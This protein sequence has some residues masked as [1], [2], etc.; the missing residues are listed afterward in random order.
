MKIFDKRPLALILCIFTGGFSLFA[1][2]DA[3]LKIVFAIASLLLAA[4]SLFLTKNS[5][6]K[7]ST[8]TLIC[9]FLLSFLYFNVAFPVNV[10]D[11]GMDSVVVVGKVTDIDLSR[12][13]V[14]AL[15]IQT[16]RIND[17]Y[18]THKIKA[19]LS[20]TDIFVPVGASV[21]FT[22]NLSRFKRIDEFD[23]EKYYTSQGYSAIADIDGIEVLSNEAFVLNYELKQIRNS[24]CSYISSL[25]DD[26]DAAGLL[27]ALLLGER[28][29][30]SNSL[31]LDFQR[32]G[33]THIL[34]LSGTHV[35]ML[36]C[37]L[38]FLLGRLGVG[39]RK[40]IFISI[41][42]AVAF[43]ALVGF[44]SSVCRAG[45]MFIISSVIYLISG[46]KDNITSLFA[47]LIIIILIEPY[48]ALDT[49]LWLSV[50]ATFGILLA[51]ELLGN[52]YD[53]SSGVRKIAKITAFSFIISFF[54][55]GMT[56]A[57]SAL[58]FGNISLL[59][60]LTTFIFSI[61]TEVY[62]YLGLILIILGGILPFIGDLLSFL[63]A[64]MKVIGA[65]FAD[66]PFVYSSAEFL[67]VKIL[68]VALTS[69]FIIFA[70][71]KILRRRAFVFTLLTL[72]CLTVTLPILLTEL[73]KSD[74]RIVYDGN[75]ADKILLYE[76]DKATFIDSSGTNTATSD[77]ALRFLTDNRVTEL[78]FYIIGSYSK[79]L[80][81]GVDE[82][83]SRIKIRALILPLPLNENEDKIARHVIEIA[84]GYRATVDF[85]KKGDRYS[86]GDAKF[87]S[88][89]RTELGESV[90]TAFAIEYAGDLY[91]YISSGAL[92]VLPETEALLF[93]S[94]T[95][96]LGSYGT[97]YKSFV[98]D[99]VAP[100]LKQ[101]IL[102]SDGIII[103]DDI[104]SNTDVVISKKAQTV[105]LN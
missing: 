29:R 31:T 46:C 102:H 91:S 93:T 65:F 89:A 40:A 90:S 64:F 54:A 25:T 52:E 85:Y 44:P 12:S 97:E 4:Y 80:P 78:D 86:L 92:K 61:L 49:G 24:I 47:A 5:L 35:S 94:K 43:M 88:V 7:A 34:A 1:A 55:I 56:M 42:F 81:Y 87:L 68:C 8:A 53:T 74:E 50:T 82:M 13:Y 99:K 60:P 14:T 79:S 36:A 32:M 41:F 75:G 3:T 98:I 19:Y 16:E 72:M 11:D 76:S 30:M 26:S 101:I 69:G 104:Y 39:K 15:D 58:S 71:I 28:D 51:V 63:C 37:G 20:D 9:S 22:A 2:V 105:K 57:I 67:S 17:K 45:I 21:R 62:I 27:S 84:S 6:F 70:V 100:R 96:I 23:A 18:D 48:A 10:S 95:V 33:I 83:L 73:D 66:L 103:E 77:E 38:L 59:A